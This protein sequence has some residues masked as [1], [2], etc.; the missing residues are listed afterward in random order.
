LIEIQAKM[1]GPISNKI[2]FRTPGAA[3]EAS[4]DC[5]WKQLKKQKLLQDDPHTP[6][7]AQVKLETYLKRKRC[8]R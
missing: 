8:N 4:L 1:I 3:L 7:S 5:Y 2:A 6:A